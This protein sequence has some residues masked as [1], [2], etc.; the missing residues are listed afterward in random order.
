MRRKMVRSLL[1]LFMAFSVIF[2]VLSV[3]VKGSDAE[4]QNDVD[5][6]EMYRKYD[7]ETG[8]TTLVSKFAE[9][10]Y[11]RGERVTY[12]EAYSPEI[13]KETDDRSVIGFDDRNKVTN[14]TSSPYYGVGRIEATYADGTSS[15]GTGFMVSPNVMLTAAHV[16][17]SYT[18]I[19]SP[20]TS[21]TVYLGQNGNTTP[22]TA[23]ASSWYVCANYTY[24]GDDTK[25][26]YAIVV[27]SSN[28][29]NTTGWFGL[30]YN[31]NDSFFY[32][33]GFTLVGY[34]GDKGFGEMWK[35][36]G[37]VTNCSTYVLDHLIDSNNGQSGGPIYMASS[38]TAY[39][40][41]SSGGGS[42]NYA[43]RMTSEV[44]DWLVAQGFIS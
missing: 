9:P 39:G 7:L 1:G 12:T 4:K 33:N 25:D 17:F 44:F 34:P 14:T 41:H 24:F 32:N 21:M 29:G 40:I 8:E 42:V 38:N 26:D 28:V 10:T 31:S 2:S 16:C 30:G 23:Y 19:T 6:S 27:L 13:C 20:L 37:V 5:L 43:R 3:N 36:A 15:C 11:V 18:N 35:A 22:T